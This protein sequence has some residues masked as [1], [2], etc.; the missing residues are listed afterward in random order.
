MAKFVYYEILEVELGAKLGENLR[1]Y[2]N[3]KNLTEKFILLSFPCD[4][5]SPDSMM[6]MGILVNE[7]FYEFY[8][9]LHISS[10][11]IKEALSIKGSPL[12]EQ[13]G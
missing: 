12:I 3:V 13:Y 2:F 8:S 6:L 4:I 11:Y 5:V 7:I 1:R 10:W 9:T